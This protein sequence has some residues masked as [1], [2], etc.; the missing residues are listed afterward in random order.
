VIYKSVFE[1]SK[2]LFTI[3]TKSI[4]FLTF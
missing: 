2:E 3:E 4:T 1:T